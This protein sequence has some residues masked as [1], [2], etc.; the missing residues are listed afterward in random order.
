LP[1]TPNSEKQVK[2]KQKDTLEKK[3]KKPPTCRNLEYE[4]LD[5]DTMP[6]ALSL[7]SSP[8]PGTP[9]TQTPINSNGT[10]SE[11][12]KVSEKLILSMSLRTQFNFIYNS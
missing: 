6:A 11:S 3:G 9:N 2:T 1:L 12:T 5:L 7:V 4:T 10:I 8:E